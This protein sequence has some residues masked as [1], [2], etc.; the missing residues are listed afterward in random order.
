MSRAIV[1]QLAVIVYHN[2][3]VTAVLRLTSAHRSNTTCELERVLDGT[4]SVES[5]VGEYLPHLVVMRVITFSIK[6]WSQATFNLPHQL[7]ICL[8]RSFDVT[9]TYQIPDKCGWRMVRR[10]YKVAHSPLAPQGLRLST[11]FTLHIYHHHGLVRRRPQTHSG[12]Q[13]SE[14]AFCDVM[15]RSVD[16]NWV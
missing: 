7:R 5:D 14:L 6:E 13:S 4:D 8:I 16:R 3:N 1:L 12:S 2:L 15:L 10:I 9:V 11:F